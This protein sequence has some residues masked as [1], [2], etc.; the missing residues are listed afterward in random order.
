MDLLAQ[1][2]GFQTNTIWTFYL[3][4]VVFFVSWGLLMLRSGMN[5]GKKHD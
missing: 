5:K 4:I 2:V 3:I 1:S